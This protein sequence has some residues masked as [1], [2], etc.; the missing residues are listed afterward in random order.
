[1]QLCLSVYARARLHT[2][3]FTLTVTEAVS[4]KHRVVVG[5]IAQITLSVS[6]MLLALFGYFVPDWRIVGRV[7]SGVVIPFIVV[8]IM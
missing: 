4:V 7:T 3:V 6:F 8:Y 5:Q 1:M 2:N